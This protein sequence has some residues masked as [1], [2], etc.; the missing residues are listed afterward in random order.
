MLLHCS[1][2]LH[3]LGSVAGNFFLRVSIGVVQCTCGL[4]LQAVSQTRLHLAHPVL[5]FR[6]EPLVP[7][8]FLTIPRRWW[9]RRGGSA[10]V[11]VVSDF[12]VIDLPRLHVGLFSEPTNQGSRFY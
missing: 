6:S 11:T 9:G 5:A 2:V 10:V 4:N 8:L 7:I 3:Y 1:L 12:N